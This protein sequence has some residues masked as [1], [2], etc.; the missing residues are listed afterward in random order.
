MLAVEMDQD[1]SDKGRVEKND[2][3]VIAEVKREQ[4]QIINDVAG[5]TVDTV[6]IQESVTPDQRQKETDHHQDE[7]VKAE[8]R[9]D[10]QFLFARKHSKCG[11][12]KPPTAL[13]AVENLVKHGPSPFLFASANS[14]QFHGRAI[15]A[16]KGH[17]RRSLGGYSRLR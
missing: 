8:D 10:E 9:K 6:D 5:R 15:L 3:E 1:A 13:D 4:E 14:E 11:L 2:H 7:R 17:R 16:S 12:G